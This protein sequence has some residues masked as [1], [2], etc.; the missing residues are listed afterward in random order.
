LIVLAA[1]VGALQDTPHAAITPIQDRANAEEMLP[2]V[3]IWLLLF[4]IVTV[5]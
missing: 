4:K 5:P 3:V 1:N 2:Q